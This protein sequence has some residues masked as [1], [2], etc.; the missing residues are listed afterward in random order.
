MAQFSNPNNLSV[1][2]RLRSRTNFTT[3]RSSRERDIETGDDRFGPTQ[4]ELNATQQAENVG[5]QEASGGAFGHSRSRED[6]RQ[7]AM[8]SMRRSLGLGA[9]EHEQQLAEKVVPAQIKGQFDVEAARVNAEA[10]GTRQQT[11]EDSILERLRLRDDATAGRQAATREGQFARQEDAQQFK[12]DN[13][14]GAQGVVPQGLYQQLQEAQEARSGPLMR[15]FG[16]GGAAEESHENA[17]MNLLDR[18]GNLQDTTTIARDLQKYPGSLQERMSA[19]AADP[20]LGLD[21]GDI[22][23]LQNLSPYQLQYLELKLGAE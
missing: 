1:L 18:Q 11:Q 5:V 22:A 21:E 4:G 14:T 20:T 2:Q 17:L 8:H 7:D 13:P 12:V 23:F 15:K 6:I 3:P 16:F 9:I 19:L 10:A